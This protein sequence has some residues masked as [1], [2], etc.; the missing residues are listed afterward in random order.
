LVLTP[1]ARR[2][3][4]KALIWSRENF[5]ERAAVRY[6]DPIKQALRD[7][8]SNPER[9]GSQLRP[10]LANVIRTYHLLFSRDRARTSLGIVQEPRHFVVYR[11]RGERVIEILRL[12]HD[13]RDLER[14][15]PEND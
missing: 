7:I 1:A 11:Y 9:P 10:E 15:L 6:R 14:H 5:G 12:L 4:R 8:A 13:A 3:F 2:D